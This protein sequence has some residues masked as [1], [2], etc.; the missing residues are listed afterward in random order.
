[1]GRL[2]WFTVEFG[3]I[4][5]AGKVKI[6][7]SGLISSHGEGKLCFACRSWRRAEI[8]DFNLDQV[9]DQ[10]FLVSESKRSF[11]RSIRLT[12]FTRPRRRR[13]SGWDEDLRGTGHVARRLG[14][15][16]MWDGWEEEVRYVV[17]LQ[18][19][20]EARSASRG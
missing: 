18:A 19:S 15:R 11:T 8:R 14:M 20:N 7:G 1:M 3:V 2:F 5:Q 4:R 13:R 12:R 16:P 17:A 9:L 10:E 6:Y